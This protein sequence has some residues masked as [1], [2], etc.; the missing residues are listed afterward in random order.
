MIKMRTVELRTVELRTVELRILRSTSVSHPHLQIS[1]C[2][3]VEVRTSSL[4]Q[5]RTEYDPHFYTILRSTLGGKNVEMRTSSDLPI[6]V[7]I[8]NS[9]ILWLLK[10]Q[11]AHLGT[12]WQDTTPGHHFYQITSKWPLT[13]GAALMLGPA[14]LY[15]MYRILPIKGASPNKGAP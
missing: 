12:H 7:V 6:D 15:F 14:L 1:V 13:Q 11:Y 5:C 2:Q 4:L 8:Y 9:L 3:N 10:R